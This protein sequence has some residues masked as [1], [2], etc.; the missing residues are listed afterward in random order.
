MEWLVLISLLVL[1]IIFIVVEIIFVP[2]T[3]FVG[4]FGFILVGAGIFFVYDKHGV[5]MGNYT[6]FGC[7]IF[8]GI[9]LYYS[10][11]SGTWKKMANASVIDSKVN[12]NI[13]INMEIGSVGKSISALRP[14]GTASFDDNFFEVSTLGEFVDADT[15]IQI[16]EINNK[17]IIVEPFK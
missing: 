10:F 4:V 9:L 15:K 14:M 12:E 6:L 8:I 5:Q 13:K 2:G 11:K 3:T 16:L 7:V 1:G 17:Q